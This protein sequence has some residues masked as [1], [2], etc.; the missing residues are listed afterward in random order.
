MV[1]QRHYFNVY[2]VNVKKYCIVYCSTNNKAFDCPVSVMHVNTI[3]TSTKTEH[4]SKI[5]NVS[6]SVEFQESNLTKQWSA[7][8]IKQY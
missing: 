5:L 1:I 2:S 7:I 3:D 6:I 8:E 4:N